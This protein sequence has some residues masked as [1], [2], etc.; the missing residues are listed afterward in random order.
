MSRGALDER[1]ELTDSKPL[2]YKVALLLGGTPLP[3]VSTERM[4]RSHPPQSRC[5]PSRH[6]PPLRLRWLRRPRDAPR[7]HRPL[8]RRTVLRR[9]FLA[10]RAGSAAALFVRGGPG[11]GLGRRAARIGIGCAAAPATFEM[12]GAVLLQHKR[13][14]TGATPRDVSF[15]TRG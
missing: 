4:C 5:R 8:P 12:S 2:A 6:L 13:S 15:R 9:R 10:R 3:R 7:R 1:R 11:A 14:S